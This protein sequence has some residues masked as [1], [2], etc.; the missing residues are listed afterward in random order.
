MTEQAMLTDPRFTDYDEVV[1]VN[2][3]NVEGR[4]QEGF[5]LLGVIPSSRIET[6]H[7]DVPNPS[8]GD[9]NSSYGYAQTISTMVSH[10]IQDP[11]FIMGRSGE[12]ATMAGRLAESQKTVL[13]LQ[14][15]AKERE[16]KVERLQGVVT[17][18]EQTNG[19]LSKKF[20]DQ[21]IAT[22]ELREKAR[23]YERDMGKIR[24]AV[25]TKLMTEIL[26]GV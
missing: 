4:S 11:L 25:G 26:G 20:N 17:H 18:M 16:E 2:Q 10:V 7:Q 12:D 5:K 19:S 6:A 1:V 13:D 24:E 3:Y 22:R 21:N 15:E 8:F 23:K 14:T 9:N